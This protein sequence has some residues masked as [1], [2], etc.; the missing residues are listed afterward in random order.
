MNLAMQAWEAGQP[1]RM[2]QLLE[3]QRPRFDQDDMRGFDWYYLWRLSQGTKRFS[4][5]TLNYDNASPLAMS[6]DGKTL[7]SGYGRTV[8]LWDVSTGL[9]SGELPGHDRMVRYLALR[10]TARRSP[11]AMRPPT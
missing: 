3:S 6:P 11:R 9:Q 8:R 4:L 5:P 10:R 1:A 2:L 7:A